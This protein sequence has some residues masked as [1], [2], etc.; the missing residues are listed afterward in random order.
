MR[1]HSFAIPVRNACSNF[2]I[3]NI[4]NQDI[5]PFR[6]G[7]VE[8]IRCKTQRK[9]KCPGHLI[10]IGPKAKTALHAA[11]L[12]I[13]NTQ[14]DTLEAHGAIHRFKNNAQNVIQF[15]T[16]NQRIADVLNASGENTLGINHLPGFGGIVSE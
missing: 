13:A 5:D 15:K 6:C 3:I 9:T 4:T 1:R 7:H 11:R 12:G 14:D 2:G 16:I 10:G 8:N